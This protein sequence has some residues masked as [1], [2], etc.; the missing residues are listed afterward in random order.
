MP[1]DD[2]V[3]VVHDAVDS[4]R[5]SGNDVERRKENDEIGECPQLWRVAGA[6]VHHLHID[7]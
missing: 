3:D 5:V 1:S 7:G 4:E 2:N 6:S